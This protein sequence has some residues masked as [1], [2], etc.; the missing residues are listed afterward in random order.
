LRFCAVLRSRAA[1]TARQSLPGGDHPCRVV[2]GVDAIRR[3][4]RMA[5]RAGGA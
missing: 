2:N 3:I 1:S 5:R 4:G